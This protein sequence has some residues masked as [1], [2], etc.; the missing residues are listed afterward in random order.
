MQ[1]CLVPSARPPLNSIQ[2]TRV[3]LQQYVFSPPFF[4]ESYFKTA[5]VIT[6][7]KIL[8]R[9]TLL[10]RSFL[11]LNFF[12]LHFCPFVRIDRRRLSLDDRFP[13]RRQLAILRDELALRVGH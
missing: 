13:F 10:R 11:Q 9:G 6:T 1:A 4:A 7:T 3:C 5:V 2:V 12:V 8:R